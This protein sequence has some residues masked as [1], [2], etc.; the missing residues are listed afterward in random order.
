MAFQ[1]PLGM[2]FGWSAAF[3]RS[4]I[5]YSLTNDPWLA[6]SRVIYIFAFLPGKVLFLLTVS[7]VAMA[8]DTDHMT[9]TYRRQISA[10]RRRLL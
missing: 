2:G 7:I 6:S 10:S 8:V 1:W 4:K 5:L 3:Y 9:L